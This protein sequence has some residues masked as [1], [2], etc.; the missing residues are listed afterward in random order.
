MKVDRLRIG[1]VGSGRMGGGIA[2]ML[3]NAGHI[4]SVQ[5]PAAASIESLPD[6][7]TSIA[8][9]LGH[10]TS[11]IDR[12]SGFADLEAIA[13]GADLIIEAAPEKL[14][15]KQDIFARLEA[16][17]P[18]HAILASNT[19]AIPIAAIAE[20]VSGRGRVIGTHFWNPPHLVRLVE[21]VQSLPGS[22]PYVERAMAILGDAGWTPVHLKRD[23]PGFVGNR[24][25][26]ALK[27]EAIALV[28]AGVCDAETVDTVV[29]M[30]FGGRLGVLGPLE[31]SDMLGL[32]L[33]QSIHDVLLPDL[34]VTPHTQDYLRQLVDQGKTGMAA[35]EGF[36]TWTVDQ[37]DRVRQRLER[38]LADKAQQISANNS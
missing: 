3:A 5:D 27:R 2:Y 24:M 11:A 9:L 14:E 36:R 22:L 25:Q 29:K 15:L 10:D 13:D 28:A 20:R 34:D 4:L 6:R 17:S 12:V 19:S 26:H 38:F 35:G 23:I 32:E 21:V 16:V 18:D 31:Q 37:A 7:L 30:G 1:I 33:T 8:T